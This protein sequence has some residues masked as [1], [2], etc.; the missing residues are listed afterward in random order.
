MGV[1]SSWTANRWVFKCASSPKSG[2]FDSGCVSIATNAVFRDD[3]SESLQEF[4]RKT[5]SVLTRGVALER[6][7]PLVYNTHLLFVDPGAP[8]VRFSPTCALLK[9]HGTGHYT[10][11]FHAFKLSFESRTFCD[12]NAMPHRDNNDFDRWIEVR[13]HKLIR[14]CYSRCQ[15]Q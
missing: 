13:I 1:K 7:S 5:L 12:N 6:S 10:L 14:L 4:T 8:T 9:H 2:S 15:N 3:G 11:Q